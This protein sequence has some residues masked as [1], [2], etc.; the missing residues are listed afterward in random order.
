MNKERWR[1]LEELFEEAVELAPDVRDRFLEEKCPE[2]PELRERLGA[3]LRHDESHGAIIGQAIEAVCRTPPPPPIE[4]E[5][6][7]AGPYRIVREVGRGGMGIVFEAVR[8]DDQFQQRVALKLAAKA[9][10]S[11]EALD[12][13]RHER[14]LLAHL[15]HPHIARLLDGGTTE[16][17]VPYFAME[18]VEGEPIHA[19]AARRNLSLEARIGL[20]FQVCDAVEYAHRNLI[21]HRDLKPSNILVANGTAKL[22]DF[23]IAKLIDPAS[24]S[25][26]TTIGT[27]PVTPDYCSPEQVRG[28][29][30]TTQTDVY[31]LGLVLY[32]LLTGERAQHADTSSPMALHRSICEIPLRS[33][34]EQARLAGNP[35]LAGLLQGDLDIV[36]QTATHKDPRRRYASVEALQSDLR[37]YL[38]RRPILARKDSSVYRLGKFARRNWLGL[39]A[40]VLLLATLLGGILAARY[41]AQR[42]ERRFAQVRRIA[43]AL[44]VDVH[45]SIQYLPAA[46]KAREVVLRTAMEYL[47]NLA[48]EAAGDRTLQLELAEGYLRVA[49]LSGS[50]I[51]PNLGQTGDAQ[52]VYEKANAIVDKLLKS[53]SGDLD[54]AVTAMRF[55]TAYGEFLNSGGKTTQASPYLLRAIGIGENAARSYPGDTKW[56]YDLGEAYSTVLNVMEDAPESH[57]HAK[58]YVEVAEQ[59]ARS[60]PETFDSLTLLGVAYSR[61][62]RVF[63]KADKALATR[64]FRQNVET[65]EKALKLEPENSSQHRNLIL[66]YANIGNA[67]LGPLA[68]D[69]YTG[70]L[71]PPVAVDPKRRMEALDAYAKAIEHAEWRVARDRSET[72]RFDYALALGRGAVAYPPKDSRAIA[73]LKKSLNLLEGLEKASNGMSLVF[74][75]EF[76]ASLAERY[77]EA[78]LFE[79]AVSQWNQLE[80]DVQRL[81]RERPEET[82]PLSL[83]LRSTLNRALAHAQRNER[84]QTEAMAA[85]AL[86]TADDLAKFASR[87]AFLAGWPARARRWLSEAYARLGDSATAS[88]M[89]AEAITAWQAILNRND[90]P[91]SLRTEAKEEMER[92]R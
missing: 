85:R 59:Y 58:R 43:N 28:E 42:A 17:D 74:S 37:S 64:Y 15:E 22:L 11:P 10:Y 6:R 36:I 33:P 62:G 72:V 9:A 50:T 48:K 16:D 61:A 55:C 27:M 71:G 84:T 77:R 12:R 8:D 76:A 3:L 39:A 47:D 88:R 60:H 2:D 63:L 66:A 5:G 92:L 45:D 40:A 82:A 24:D 83:R 38:E 30:I 21:V 70:A 31:S 56:L 53:H 7:R 34:S 90:V 25:G 87:A 68:P 1:R 14:Q 73:Q 65:Q 67:A 52:A 86:A 41:Q 13:F 91:E 18:F 44:M 46:T 19:Y 78:G 26:T 57:R 29:R 80:A 32:E 75:A 49:T 51:T 69:S 35:A 23:G 89:R 4:F 20:F 81:I 79:Q 54:V